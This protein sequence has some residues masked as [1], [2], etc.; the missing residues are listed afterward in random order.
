MALLGYAGGGQLGNFGSVGVDQGTFGFAVF[1]WFLV[2]GAITV[3]MAG[4]VRYR[5]RKP[6]PTEPVAE[7]A[8]SPDNDAPA[9]SPDVDAMPAAEPPDEER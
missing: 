9:S 5:P 4:G 3:A 6:K 1:L 7:V 2:V 8:E